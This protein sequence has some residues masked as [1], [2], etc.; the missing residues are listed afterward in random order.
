MPRHTRRN[1]SSS[2]AVNAAEDIPLGYT[3]TN[4]KRVVAEAAKSRSPYSEH[5]I[6]EWAFRY[7]FNCVELGHCLAPVRCLE[8]AVEVAQELS[9][10]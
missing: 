5:Q 8:A 4:F 10:Q 6:A 9:T 7:W 2:Q 3:A 1:K